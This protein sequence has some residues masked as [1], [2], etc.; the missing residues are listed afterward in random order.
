LKERK[1][2]SYDN[3]TIQFIKFNKS[4]FFGFKRETLD[5]KF[6]FVAEVEKAILDSLYLPKYCPISETFF[7]LKNAKL[8]IKKLLDYAKRMKSLAVIK[9]LGY[10][11][12]MIGINAT[13]IKT[14]F[15]NY[16]L[17]NPTL[18]KVGEKNERWKLII[19]E[20]LE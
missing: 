2:L 1:Q 7:A 8:D 10:L 4:R 3:N 6:I 17:L 18:Q 9:R 15:K 16:T 12:E 11:L 19:N 20:V 14:S 5:D 13:K